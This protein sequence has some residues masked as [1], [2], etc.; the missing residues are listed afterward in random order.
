MKY[1]KMIKGYDDMKSLA[2]DLG[3]LRYDKLGELIEELSKKL[4]RDSAKDHNAG[5]PLLAG[6]LYC[7]GGA[8]E[9]VKEALDKA[10]YYCHRNMDDEDCQ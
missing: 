6:E 4:Y 3:D 8:L 5:K 2:E 9:S 7:A 10:W 1:P